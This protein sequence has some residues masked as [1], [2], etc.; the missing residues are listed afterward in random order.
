MNKIQISNKIMA[1]TFAVIMISAS[2]VFTGCQSEQEGLTSSTDKAIVESVELE[3]FILAGIEYQQVIKDF[4]NAIAKVDFSPLIAQAKEGQKVIPLSGMPE[5]EGKYLELEQTRKDLLKKF[6]QFGHD[7]KQNRLLT[8]Q[9]CENFSQVIA[10]KLLDIDP[11][12]SRPRLKRYT[13]ENYANSTTL[14]NFL[15]SYV[16]SPNYVEIFMVVFED[17]SAVTMLHNTNTTTECKAPTFYKEDDGKYH[18]PG[19]NSPIAYVAHTHIYRSSAS[20]E[21]SIYKQQSPD[22]ICKI[23]YNVI[24]YAY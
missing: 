17:G 12:F 5:I 23:Y 6:P 11:S 3:N 8:L 13:I 4:R 10:R 9:K 14:N 18:A 2:F 20:G 24:F 15:S 7:T 16:N 19:Y 1:T 22:L 21:D